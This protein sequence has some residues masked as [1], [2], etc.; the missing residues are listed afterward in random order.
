MMSSSKSNLDLFMNSLVFVCQHFILVLRTTIL[1]HIV[2]QYTDYY[3]SKSKTTACTTTTDN[4]DVLS[5]DE[6]QITLFYYVITALQEYF[7]SFLFF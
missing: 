3:S 7:P 6:P 1:T 2:R 5:V 4:I